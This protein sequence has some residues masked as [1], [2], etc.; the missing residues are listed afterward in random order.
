MIKFVIIIKILVHFKLLN[1]SRTNFCTNNLLHGMLSQCKSCIHLVQAEYK[2]TD[3]LVR[4]PVPQFRVKPIHHLLDVI[5]L[6]VDSKQQ[7]EEVDEADAWQHNT[8]HSTEATRHGE[9]H[10]M[11]L[12]Q[13]RTPVCLQHS[14]DNAAG[15]MDDCFAAQ[16]G[17]VE[18]SFVQ[19]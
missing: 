4:F 16:A 7:T 14:T 8:S 1:V 13:P 11:R 6:L 9:M 18:R 2:S 10:K 12:R 5:I 17:G 3:L 15:L 19:V